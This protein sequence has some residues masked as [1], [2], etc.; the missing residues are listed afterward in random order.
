VVLSQVKIEEWNQWMKKSFKSNTLGRN[1]KQRCCQLATTITWIQNVFFFSHFFSSSNFSLKI[2]FI[3]KLF[4]K[5]KSRRS[6]VTFRRNEH[7]K[8]GQS[9]KIKTEISRGL[10]ILPA[11]FEK[12]TMKYKF[13]ITRFDNSNFTSLSWFLEKD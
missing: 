6:S 13:G 7:I 4:S 10:S 9:Y 8:K 3:V 5:E 12:N 1:P 11:S 2:L